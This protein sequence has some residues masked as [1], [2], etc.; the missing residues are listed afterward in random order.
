MMPRQAKGVI[1]RRF[2]DEGVKR[3]NLQSN[4]DRLAARI[5]SDFKSAK[6]RLETFTNGEAINALVAELLGP[7]LDTPVGGL[8]PMVNTEDQKESPSQP[9]GVRG[10]MTPA[11]FEPASRP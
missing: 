11:G 2:A 9:G 10:A 6:G 3:E 1:K 8:L 7:S 4:L 5:P